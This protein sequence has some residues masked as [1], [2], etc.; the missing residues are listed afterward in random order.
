MKASQFLYMASLIMLAPHLK[1]Q[2]AWI[3]YS[4]MF[5]AAVALSLKGK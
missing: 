2:M 1:E 4:V 5:I 3:A